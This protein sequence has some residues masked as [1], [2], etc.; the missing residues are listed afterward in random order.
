MDTKHSKL[1]TET[2]EYFLTNLGKADFQAYNFENVTKLTWNGIFN[3]TSS[4]SSSLAQTTNACKDCEFVFYQENSLNVAETLINVSKKYDLLFPFRPLVVSETSLHSTSPGGETRKGSSKTLEE[5][6][7]C[8]SNYMASV[9]RSYGKSIWSSQAKKNHSVVYPLSSYQCILSANITV[10]R[11][12]PEHKYNWLEPEKYFN[13]DVA[14]MT[15]IDFKNFTSLV[16]GSSSSDGATARSASSDAAKALVEKFEGILKLATLYKFREIIINDFNCPKDTSESLS[17][18][19]SDQQTLLVA[20]LFDQ[21]YYNYKQK[22]N[23]YQY[24]YRKLIAAAGNLEYVEIKQI[25]FAIPN[26]QNFNI[27]CNTLKKQNKKCQQNE[28]VRPQEK[29]QTNVAQNAVG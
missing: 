25:I 17:S 2:E 11:Q 19:N 26:Q 1:F 10:F 15:P 21:A 23:E 16:A 13:L 5:Q 12:G 24:Q 14:A 4:P 6:M 28:N 3:L 20:N 8:R 7:C 22:F 29:V 9:D 18:A 27:F